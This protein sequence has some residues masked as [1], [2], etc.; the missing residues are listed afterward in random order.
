MR[1]SAHPP[2]TDRC[3][4]SSRICLSQCRLGSQSQRIRTGISLPACLLSRPLR[5]PFRQ[6]LNLL[7]NAKAS[8]KINAKASAKIS[9][10][11]R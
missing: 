4:L 10:S 7:L 9:A 1:R 8:A 11:Q 3:R 2:S 6:G 5:C